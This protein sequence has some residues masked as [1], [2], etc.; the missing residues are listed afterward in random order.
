MFDLEKVKDFFAGKDRQ[1]YWEHGQRCKELLANPE[2]THVV[3]TLKER[4]KQQAF[5]DGVSTEERE[6]LYRM[7][8][9][10]EAIQREINNRSTFLDALIYE[11]ENE[12]EHRN[13]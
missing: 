7:F 2:F 13:E 11:R 4:C 3:N 9:A 8:H 6:H 1:F 5:N 10:Y 12:H